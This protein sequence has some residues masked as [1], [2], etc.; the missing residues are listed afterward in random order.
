MYPV[1][2]PNI[3]VVGVGIPTGRVVKVLLSNVSIFNLIKC[4]RSGKVVI[5]FLFIIIV[6]NVW[7]SVIPGVGKVVKLL[8]LAIRVCNEGRFTKLLGKEVNKLLYK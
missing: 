2:P 8:L 3:N 1:A 4:V 7:R 5:G 6:F